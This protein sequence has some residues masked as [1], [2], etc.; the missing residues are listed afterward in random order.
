MSKSLG[1]Q[2]C[3]S[4]ELVARSGVAGSLVTLFNLLRKHV[5]I[6]G[7]PHPHQLL[8]IINQRSPNKEG[9]DGLMVHLGH[10]Q[11]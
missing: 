1:G 10:R 9:K 5:N 6:P 11:K 4:L 2:G 8:V 7:F 3:I